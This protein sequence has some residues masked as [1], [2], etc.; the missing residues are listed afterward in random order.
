[1]KAETVV[2]RALAVILYA[3]GQSSDGCIAKL[4]GGDVP[5]CAKMATTRGGSS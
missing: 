3:P 4:F 5:N 2:K 1:M